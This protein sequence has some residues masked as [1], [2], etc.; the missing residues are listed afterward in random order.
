MRFFNGYVFIGLPHT[1]EDF[2][3]AGTARK[4][5]MENVVNGADP[6]MICNSKKREFA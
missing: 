6:Q 5:S 2:D 4:R 3:K 1:R